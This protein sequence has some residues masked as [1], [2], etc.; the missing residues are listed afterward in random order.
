[1][2][3]SNLSLSLLSLLAIST[4]ARLDLWRFL[5]GDIR[6][7]EERW[8][9]QTPQQLCLWR[10]ESCA[11]LTGRYNRAVTWHF[12]SPCTKE[13]RRKHNFC[14]LQWGEKTGILRWHPSPTAFL[15]YTNSFS[16]RG[17]WEG[18]RNGRAGHTQALCGSNKQSQMYPSSPGWIPLS[19][20]QFWR[21][22]CSG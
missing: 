14:L 4:T 13:A 17:I 11:A 20:L 1:M 6:Q 8:S 12:S 18:E 5:I 15:T 7:P 2:I 22:A 10:D 3:L 16:S 21:R 9:Y 19:F